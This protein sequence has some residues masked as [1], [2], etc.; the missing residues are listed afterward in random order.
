METK[1]ENN[2]LVIRIPLNPKASSTGRMWLVASTGGWTQTST[3]YQNQPLKVN[4]TAGIGMN[5]RQSGAGRF[6]P[7]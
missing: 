6:N 4:L 3:L 7:I 1:I 2:T 5:G